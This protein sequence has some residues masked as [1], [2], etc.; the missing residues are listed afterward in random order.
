MDRRTAGGHRRSPGISGKEL[1]DQA[2]VGID[3]YLAVERIRHGETVETASGPPPN[4]ATAKESMQ[5]K[6]L[7]TETGNAIYRLSSKSPVLQGVDVESGCTVQY[8][9]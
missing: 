9:L 4:E 2:V 5:H 6:K 8:C 1:T 3:L 7:R